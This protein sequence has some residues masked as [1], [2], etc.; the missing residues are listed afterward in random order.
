MNRK[1]FLNLMQEVGTI[2]EST[3]KP[4]TKPLNE[5]KVSGNGVS[6]AER[7]LALKSVGEKRKL[8]EAE[9]LK[10]ITS[11]K[12]IEGLAKTKGANSV[13]WSDDSSKPR[14]V[15]TAT[16]NNKA[17]TSALGTSSK[18]AAP[19]IEPLDMTKRSGGKKVDET[20][21]ET[22]ESNGEIDMPEEMEEAISVL[23]RDWKRLMGEGTWSNTKFSG[24]SGALGV[25]S[26]M[27][28]ASREANKKKTSNA[29]DIRKLG[30]VEIE[31][32]PES[33]STLSKP[34]RTP[35]QALKSANT[36][37]IQ[38]LRGPKQSGSALV[39]P[40]KVSKPIDSSYMDHEKTRAAKL[41][42][43][44]ADLKGIGSKS[45]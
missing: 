15:P 9:D 10:D 6:I 2:A 17:T 43:R 34:S 39:M 28:P 24:G 26:L 42:A 44:G 30:G 19:K 5:S 32:E 3:K 37:S 4:Y 45:R 7:T 31:D 20:P 40:P 22:E 36:A 33:T 35:Q 11:M 27:Q 1:E 38:G 14:S 12:E 18:L 41:S 21:E 13:G 8:A 16:L 29:V 23:R 25:S